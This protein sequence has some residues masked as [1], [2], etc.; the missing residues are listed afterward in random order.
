MTLLDFLKLPLAKSGHD[1]MQVHIDLLMG[2]VWLVPTFQ[3]STVEA[4]AR[5][6]IGSV[7]W[8]M[9]LPDTIVSDRDCS[10]T[11]EFWTALH[12]ALGSTLIFGS[13]DHHNTS[14]KVKLVNWVVADV[15]SAFV[16]NWQDNWLLLMQLVEFEFNYAASQLSTGFT[17][18]YADHSQ[19][20]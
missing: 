9:G 14:L 12:K 20:P 11:E 2:W 13:P 8:D 17:P 16:N 1:F 15:L 4:A 19:H 5:N 3:S 10:F 7:F 18:F 6:Y